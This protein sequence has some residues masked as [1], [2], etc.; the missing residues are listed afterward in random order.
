[1]TKTTLS[2][3]EEILPESGFI[4]IHRSFIVSINK[5]ETYSQVDVEIQG[6][7]IPIGATYKSPVLKRLNFYMAS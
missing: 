4:R 1:M 3:I 7:K 5:I 2:A 6:N